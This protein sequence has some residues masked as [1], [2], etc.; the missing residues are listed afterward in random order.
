MKYFEKLNFLNWNISIIA[1]AITGSTVA[2]IFMG[3][4]GANLFVDYGRGLPVV[5]FE[6]VS[7][8]ILICELSIALGL[9]FYSYRGKPKYI[10]TDVT[11]YSKID[12]ES[13][14][15]LDAR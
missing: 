4:L 3:I 7:L 2:T 12:N 10:I 11:H 15:L 6:L 8:S 1:G 9:L 14:A 13:L 5:S